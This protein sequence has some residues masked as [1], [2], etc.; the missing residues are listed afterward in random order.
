M[1]FSEPV[2]EDS[3]SD[4]CDSTLENMYCQSRK[5]DRDALSRFK[6]RRAD[7]VMAELK[8]FFVDFVV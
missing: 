3:D 4:S 5:I 2:I 1:K 7:Q 8:D 6:P